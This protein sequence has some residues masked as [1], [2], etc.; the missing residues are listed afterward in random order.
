M[1][2]EPADGA[3]G[4]KSVLHVG[5]LTTDIERSARRLVDLFGGERSGKRPSWFAAEEGVLSTH[6][7]FEGGSIEPLEPIR[8]GTMQS[9]RL[10]RGKHAFHVAVRVESMDAAV[11]HIRSRGLSCQVRGIGEVVQLRRGWVHEA[12]TFG[13]PIELLD[14]GELAAFRGPI[15]DRGR[16]AAATGRL[17]TGVQYTLEAVGHVVGDLRAAVDLYRDVLGFHAVDR[18]PVEVPGEGFVMQR[19]RL[20]EGLTIEVVSPT[21]RRSVLGLRLECFGEGIGYV[22]MSTADLAHAYAALSSAEA[23]LSKYPEDDALPERLWVDE[24]SAEGMP[25]LVVAR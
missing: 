4:A 12:S 18:E 8:P 20:T 14:A 23:Y 16:P 19:L 15:D 3:C 17:A 5:L 10:A 13:L 11:E 25:V 6:V 7:L 1:T 9:E 2:Y 21:R 24:R 22:K